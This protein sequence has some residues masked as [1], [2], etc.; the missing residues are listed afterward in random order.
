[1]GDTA[2]PVGQGETVVQLQ[3]RIETVSG[4]REA[5]YEQCAK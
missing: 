1:M 3:L 4:L 5:L 2:P